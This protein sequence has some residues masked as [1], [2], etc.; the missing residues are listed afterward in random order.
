MSPRNWQERI[1]DILDAVDEVERFIDGM[2]FEQF[3]Q[4]TKTIYAVSFAIATIGEAAG[5][6]GPDIKLRHPDVPWGQMQAM[7]NVVIHQYFRIELTILWDTATANL[8]TLI[9]PL[10]RLREAES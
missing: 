10:R 9:E 4:D 8:P 5:D 1:D 6:I 7:R 3:A 2:S